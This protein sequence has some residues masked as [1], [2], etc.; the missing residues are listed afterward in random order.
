MIVTTFFHTVT[1]RTH[2]NQPQLPH[3]K[4]CGSPSWEAVSKKIRCSK[5]WDNSIR[6]IPIVVGYAE[7]NP[8]FGL[9]YHVRVFI[10]DFPMKNGG[11][12]YSC[13]SHYQRVIPPFL[14]DISPFSS[15]Y[16]MV[17][18]LNKQF[19]SAS[20]GGHFFRARSCHVWRAQSELQ[21]W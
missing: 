12:F 6:L 21:R 15:R 16:L 9:L 17:T 7:K 3:T 10:V 2:R 11:S 4:W 14:I 20:P 1:G 18:P 5:S 19:C 8:D 13:V